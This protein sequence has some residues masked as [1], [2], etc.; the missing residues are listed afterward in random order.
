MGISSFIANRLNATG[1]QFGF[2]KIIVRIAAASIAIG[3]STM[4]ISSA[5]IQGFKGEIHQKIFG[6]WGHIHV[7][8]INSGRNFELKALEVTDSL[9]LE[10][11]D[12]KEVHMNLQED[13]KDTP[14]MIQSRGGITEAHRFLILPGLLEHK[15]AF[16]AI[17]FKGLDQEIKNSSIGS[18]LVEGRLPRIESDSMSSEIMVSRIIA[19]K[20]NI[21]IGKPVIVSFV[22]DQSRIKRKFEVVGIYNTGLEE[23]DKRFIVGDLR[24]LQQFLQWAPNEVSGVE[25]SLAHPEDMDMISAFLYSE[26]LPLDAISETIRERFPSIFDWLELQNINEKVILRLM[27][28]VGIINMITVL[29]ILILE[30]TPMIGILKALGASDWQIQKIFLVQGAYI[31]FWGQLIGNV[32]G[33]GLCYAQETFGFIKLDEANYYLDT[34]PISIQFAQ[35]ASINIGAFLITFIFLLLPSYLVTRIKPVKALKFS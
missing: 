25:I 3:V 6:F 12:I 7:T 26:V 10:L 31:I 5:L 2:T 33:L 1:S 20:L 18:F 13:I 15:S 24:K 22:K 8:N 28:L 19:S 23:Y 29:L 9:L 14:F 34:A 17:L 21:P 27:A 35:V 30:R 32:L 4:I 16:E 11:R